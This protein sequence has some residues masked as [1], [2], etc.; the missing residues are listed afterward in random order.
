[1]SGTPI[2]PREFVDLLQYCL[3]HKV[4]QSSLENAVQQILLLSIQ[5]PS[6]DQIM[7]VLGNKPMDNSAEFDDESSRQILKESQKLINTVNL[8]LN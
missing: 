2:L 6:T 7:A 5:G 3:R 4:P 1:M 8:L